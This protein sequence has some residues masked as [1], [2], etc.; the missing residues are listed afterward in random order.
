VGLIASVASSALAGPAMAGAADAAAEVDSNVIVVTAQKREQDVQDVPISMTVAS[1]QKLTTMGIQDFNQ[2]DR[3]VP[4]FYVQTTPGNNAF[5]IRGI[6]STPG[7]LAFEQTVGLFVDGVYGGHARQFQAPFLDVARIEVMRGPQGALVGK[8]TSAGAISVISA[9]PTFELQA[10]AEGSYEFEPGGTRLYGM[11]SGPISEAVAVR[12]AA[13]YEDYDGYIENLI[14]GGK[15]TKRK[16]LFGRA[17]ILVDSGGPVDF[18]LKVEGGHVDLTGTASEQILTP[19]DPD[20]KRSTGGFPGF[21]DRDFDNTNNLNLTAIANLEIGEHVLTSISG[22]SSYDFEKRLDA[23]FGP[24]PAFASSFAEKFSQMSQELRLA[25]PETGTVEYIFGGY[26]HVNDYDLLQTT[27]IKFG[28]FNGESDR[29][30][31]QENVV[32]SGFGNVTW[33]M[34]E[35]LRLIGGLRYTFDRKR[36]NQTRHKTGVVLPTWLA[37]PLSGQRTEREW[38][39]SVAVQWNAT[40]EAMLYASYGQGS[41]AGGFVGAQATTTPAQFQVE[42]ESAETFEV[43]AKLALLDR[44][45]RINTALFRTDFRNLQVSSFDAVTTSFITSNAGKARSQ[46]FEGDLSFAITEGFLLTGSLA[47]LDAKFLDFPGAQC[48]YDN[49]SCVPADNN[50][51]GRP[52]PRSPKWS[53]TLSADLTLP[54]SDSLEFNINAGM[55][56]RSFAYL[57]ESYDPAAGQDGHAKFDLRA[58]IRSADDRW[59]LAFLGKNLTNEITASHA[60]ATPLAANVISKFIQQPRSIAVQAKFRY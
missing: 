46:G 52:L 10:A 60:F 38:D 57:E 53:G 17:S 40:P 19:D 32:W 54:A 45:L 21:V 29:V 8:N 37:T 12:V 58:A 33:H 18:L 20:L 30:F 22:Y 42:S 16:T 49:L 35:T 23:D 41:K 3:F 43:G 56:F 11:V 48:P 6:G 13:Q 50:A 31:R 39:P 55:T 4:N 44:R 34:S 7:N 25:S 24:A 59:E 9:R 26:F 36:A 5:Y 1:G 51:A 47:Y 27:L 28:P 15:E 2:L 14:L